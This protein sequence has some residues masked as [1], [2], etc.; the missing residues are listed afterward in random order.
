[1]YSELSKTS[2]MELFTNIVNYIQLLTIFAKRSTLVVSQGRCA[3]GETKE[4]LGGLSFISQKK[5][6]LQYLQI[7]CTFKFNF[8]FTLLPYGETLIANSIHVSL[9]SN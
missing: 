9:I 2:K 7:S 5:P 8:I 3:S 1:M 4:K 6:E